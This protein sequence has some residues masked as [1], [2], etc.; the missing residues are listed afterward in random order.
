VIL[1][2]RPGLRQLLYVPHGSI[3]RLILPQIIFFVS[4]SAAVVFA[5]KTWPELVR[6]HQPGP[7]ALMG[8][9]LSI[10]FSFRN[11]ACYQRWWEGRRQWG[12]LVLTARDFARQTLVLEDNATAERRRLL[13][14]TIAFCHALVPHLRPG[15]GH[16]KRDQA[17]TEAD[18][19]SIRD[20]HNPPDAIAQLIGRE[21]ARLRSS[22]LITDIVFQLLDRTASEFAAVQGACERIHNTPLPYSYHLLLQRTAYLFCLALPFGFVDTLGW[23][24]I[25]VTIVIA[26]T[27]FGLDVLADDLEQPFGD[28]PNNLP[29]AALADVIEIDLRAALGE[30]DLPP[31]PQP[32]DS[33]LL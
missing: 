20:S 29:I 17:L 2:P 15:A 9:A 16:G 13:M 12:H 21:L 26:Y 24:T 22:G 10:F 32:V 31:L 6:G 7:Y 25:P 30:T 1:R 14:L 8:V 4:L 5:H 18:L 3:M 27:F 11:N 19:A 33:I 23:V 28:R